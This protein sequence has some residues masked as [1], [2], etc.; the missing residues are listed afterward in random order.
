MALPNHSSGCRDRHG[1]S[2]RHLGGLQGRGGEPVPRGGLAEMASWGRVK[3]RHAAAAGVNCHASGSLGLCGV[4]GVSAVVGVSVGGSGRRGGDL[5]QARMTWGA[6]MSR[7]P[8]HAL[9][10]QGCRGA[11][12]VVPRLYRPS[13]ETPYSSSRC[14]ALEYPA[15]PCI[16]P[17]PARYCLPTLPW[18]PAVK[19]LSTFIHF[20][21]LAQSATSVASPCFKLPS[22]A[23]HGQPV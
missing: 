16:T 13:L 20:Y 7:T 11:S 19:Q 9:T 4:S 8:L 10:M 1:A 23:R 17:S 2:R 12:P 21:K 15:L 14:A 3:M 18:R 6:F 5:R 22:C